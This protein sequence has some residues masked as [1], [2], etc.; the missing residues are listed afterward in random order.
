MSTA[1][2]FNSAEFIISFDDFI[3][4]LD[5]VNMSG[6]CTGCESEDQ[7]TVHTTNSPDSDVE[8]DWDLTVYKLSFAS[9]QTFRPALMMNCA[10]CGT[11][12][13]IEASVVI[14][15]LKS[16]PKDATDE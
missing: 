2:D 8:D 3:R 10:V 14:N 13:S 1:A 15:W 4:F 6:K 16:N 7:W 5:G 11:I 12:R 9:N